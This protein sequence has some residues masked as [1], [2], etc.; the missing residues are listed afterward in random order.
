M[1]G[2]DKGWMNGEGIG[3]GRSHVGGRME[4]RREV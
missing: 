1:G 3:R 2:M 4:K